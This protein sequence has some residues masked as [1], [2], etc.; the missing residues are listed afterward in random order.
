MAAPR[1]VYDNWQVVDVLPTLRESLES[2]MVAFINRNDRRPDYD[3]R[4]P[5]PDTNSQTLY[6]AA[7]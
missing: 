4:T 1:F 2:P 6:F 7:P 5:R 3:V